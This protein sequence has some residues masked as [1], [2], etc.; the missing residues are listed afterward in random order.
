MSDDEPIDVGAELERVLLSAAGPNAS[1]FALA[2]LSGIP[3]VGG[4]FSAAAGA[5]SD[6]E[7]DRINRITAAWLRLQEE[8]LRNVARTLGEVVARVD[9]MGSELSLEEFPEPGL[10]DP[11]KWCIVPA[12]EVK[13][14]TAWDDR[15]CEFIKFWVENFLIGKFPVTYEQ[16]TTFYNAPNGYGNDQWWV[17]L[18]YDP[19]DSPYRF[20]ELELESDHDILLPAL[21]DRNEAIA[22]C[23]WLSYEMRYTIIVPPEPHWL[24]AARGDD[25]RKFPWGDHFDPLLCN[26]GL[27][28]IDRETPVTRYPTG[29]SQFGVVD[30]CGNAPEWCLLMKTSRDI[31]YSLN[32]GMYHPRN[33][34][35]YEKDSNR[36]RC[37]YRGIGSSPIFG[38]PACFRVCVPSSIVPADQP[39]DSSLGIK[40]HKE[41]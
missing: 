2:S 9:R 8:D 31:I 33:S 40:R 7:Q 39:S 21:V 37:A 10:P 26:S 41:A 29:A 27:S 24:R 16:Y 32:S 3:G 30:L 28:G 23:R 34:A 36:F 22:F 13:L 38:Y 20:R 12:G 18:Q 17:D 14:L 6:A 15:D 35:F 11:F 5:W 4:L 19:R 1:R 25:D